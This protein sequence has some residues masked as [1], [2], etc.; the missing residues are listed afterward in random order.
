MSSASLLWY[1]A[2]E[3]ERPLDA[4]TVLTETSGVAKREAVMRL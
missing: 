1:L 2:P 4:R 3:L